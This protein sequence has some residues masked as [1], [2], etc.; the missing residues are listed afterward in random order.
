MIRVE[1]VTIETSKLPPEIKNLRIVQL[2]DIHFSPLTSVDAARRIKEIVE[3]EKPDLLVS[4]GD[5]LDPGIRDFEDVAWIMHGI[6]APLGKYAVT[7]NH[8]FISNI[9][10]STLFTNLLGFRLLRNEA[11]D[12]KGILNIAGIDDPAGERFG[13]STN[14]SDLDVLEKLDNDKYTIYLKHRPDVDEGTLDLFDLQ[15]S[16]HTHSGQIFPFT[17][18]VK[19]VYPYMAGLYKLNEDTNLYVSRGTGTW[20]PPIRFLAFPEI[21]VIDLKNTSL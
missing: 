16:G 8:E 14:L 18:F 20:G 2:S 12:V 19:I 3:R 11:A 10:K 15:L 5:L 21:T 13:I 4:T 9:Q 7:G 6:R 1:R 17:L